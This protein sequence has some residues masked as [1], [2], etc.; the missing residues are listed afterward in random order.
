MPRKPKP[1]RLA[2]LRRA[3]RQRL[4]EG[5]ADETAALEAIARGEHGEG[6]FLV[7][8]YGGGWMLTRRQASY[9]AP[10]EAPPVEATPVKAPAELPRPEPVPEHVATSYGALARRQAAENAPPEP[11]EFEA[12]ASIMPAPAAPLVA[13]PA[14]R[15]PRVDW[16]LYRAPGAMELASQAA[17]TQVELYD[18]ATLYVET[19]W[20]WVDAQARDDGSAVEAQAELT[21]AQ[22]MLRD[23][24]ASLPGSVPTEPDDD[25]PA[26]RVDLYPHLRE[27]M[28]TRPLVVIGGHEVAPTIAW[29]TEALGAAP[30]W[31]ETE[32]GDSIDPGVRL[33]KRVRE[34]RVAAVVVIQQFISHNISDVVTQAARA[35]RVPFALGGK[36]G[37][38]AMRLALHT[39]ET[40]LA[41]K[42]VTLVG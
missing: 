27:R 22:H 25:A 26:A 1:E 34:H 8:T 12:P 17:G 4:F 5:V 40:V 38:P 9:R 15:A 16:K 23:I 14:L 21:L 37:R 6:D 10:A 35:A 31:V 29:I 41:A 2:I 39:I 7:E 20:R 28:R 32:S 11:P 3:D 36:G 30:E 33:A 13:V 18:A 42:R 24:A 19:L